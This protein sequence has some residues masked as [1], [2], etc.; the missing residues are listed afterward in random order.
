MLSEVE[1]EFNIERDVV[2]KKLIFCKIDI[3]GQG[4]VSLV[5]IV[6]YS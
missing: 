1:I 6:S 3:L 2:V 5:Y 4:I